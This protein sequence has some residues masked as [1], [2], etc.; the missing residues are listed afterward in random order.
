MKTMDELRIER[1]ELSIAD[2]INLHRE[3]YGPRMEW[4]N[5][6]VYVCFREKEIDITEDVE[7][8]AVKHLGDEG[9]NMVSAF[10]ESIETIVKKIAGEEASSSTMTSQHS[11]S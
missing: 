4:D 9:F 7:N 1:P 11:K 2:S 5:R 6:K 8:I 10:N 3:L